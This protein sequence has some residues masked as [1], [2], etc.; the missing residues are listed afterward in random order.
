MQSQNNR[1]C[2]KPTQNTRA[3]WIIQLDIVL[4]S[5]FLSL[6]FSLFPSLSL[7]LSFYHFITSIYN[8]QGQWVQKAGLLFCHQFVLRAACCDR[9]LGSW[10]AAVAVSFFACVWAFSRVHWKAEIQYVWGWLVRTIKT[11]RGRYT[12]TFSRQSLCEPVCACTER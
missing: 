12:F 2:S 4:G 8:S 9:A 6:S 3:Y 11:R 7:S 5:F 1:N 10:D